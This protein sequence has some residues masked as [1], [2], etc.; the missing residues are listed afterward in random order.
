M[1]NL[2]TVLDW[3][4]YATSQLS[5]PEVENKL[6]FAH[7]NFD[8]F[9][10]A[11]S[12]V[13]GLLNLPYELDVAYFHAHLTNAE[14]NTLKEGLETRINDKKP[15]PYITQRTLFMGLEFYVDERVL[16]P[17]SP[18]AELIENEVIPYANPYEVNRVLDLCCGS[19]CIGIAASYIFEDA[20]VVLADIDE[21]ALE[22][23]TIN[24]DKHDASDQVSIVQSDLFAAFANDGKFDDKFDLILSNPPYVDA[25]TVA[26]LPAEFLH[27]PSIALGSGDDGLACTRRIL[28]EAINY[29]TPNG[30][31]VVEVGASWDLLEKAYPEVNFNWHQFS[32]GGEG[33]FVMSYD[34][35]RR[36]QAIFNAG[37]S[38]VQHQKLN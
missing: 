7:G 28:A 21:K 38:N 33:V 31:L 16:I 2:V 10:E 22:V 23:A 11:H 1:K 27:E 26:H 37:L 19:G 30:V 14:I 20:D 29:L 34:E 17:R 8:A 18:M 25:D 35:L 6:V 32:K 4:R 36:Y 3:I 15:V 24:V 5:R 9:G 12:L 13:L